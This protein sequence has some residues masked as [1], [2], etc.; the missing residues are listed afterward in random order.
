MSLFM[1]WAH[2]GIIEATL[3][4]KVKNAATKKRLKSQT[5]SS[6]EKCPICN[7]SIPFRIG[8]HA[9]CANGHQWNRC[10]LTLCIVDWK[11]ASCHVCKSK[12]SHH[13]EKDELFATFRHCIYCGTRMY[14]QYVK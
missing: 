13:T 10:Q 7:E 6:D 12:K 4:Q 3:M 9:Q 11:S 8:Q 1:K 5:I 2:A 14:S